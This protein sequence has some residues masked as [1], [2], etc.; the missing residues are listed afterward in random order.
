MK[1]FISHRNQELDLSLARHF[2]QQLRESGHSPYLAKDLID[3]GAEWGPEIDEQLRHCDCLLLLLSDGAAKSDAVIAEVEIVRRRSARPRI[4]ILRIRLSE[5]PGYDL[6]VHIRRYQYLEWNSEA[7]TKSVTERLL[8]ALASPAVEA[9][10]DAPAPTTDSKLQTPSP[11]AALPGGQL[12]PDSG[13]YQLRTDLDAPA[14]AHILRP[15]SL[16]AVK[17]ARQVGK[18]SLVGRVLTEAERQGCRTAM[19]GL[20]LDPGTRES[21]S[22]FLSWFCGQVAD[23]LGLPTVPPNPAAD[24]GASK[25]FFQRH[26]LSLNVPIVIALDEVDMLNSAPNIAADFLFMLRDWNQRGVRDQ[27]WA[28]LRLIVCYSTEGRMIVPGFGSPLGN[29]AQSL[30]MRDFQPS[31]LAQLANSY[32]R[33][34]TGIDQSAI[35]WIHH[36]TNGHPYLAAV[37]LHG[38]AVKRI[39]PQESLSWARLGPVREHLVR[40]LRLLAIDPSLASRL[41]KI[42]QRPQPAKILDDEIDKLEAAGLV[43]RSMD[44]VVAPR[45]RLYERFFLRQLSD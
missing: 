30:T 11:T 13:L 42:C 14:L 17:G 41:L 12:A 45:C 26:V 20:Q 10:T 35:D 36:E 22:G 31:E 29:V 33:L 19:L 23:Q 25:E 44:E 1:V 39:P 6:Y 21:L 9:A 37:A 27:T 4:F 43:S 7:D 2:F 32:S 3:F 5:E 34:G 15:H 24:I 28:N 8:A 38:V 40:L 18:T 16:L